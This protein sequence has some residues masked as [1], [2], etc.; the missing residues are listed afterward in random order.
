M[1]L[2]LDERVVVVTGGSSGIGLALVRLLLTE[3][4]RVATCGRSPERLEA[5]LA[6]LLADHGHRLLAQ[7]AD[8]TDGSA[9]DRL[10]TSTVER[11]GGID[12]LVNNA[13]QSRLST[14]ASTTDDEWRQELE[15][16]FFG[17]LHPIRAA[18]SALRAS[19]LGAIVNLGAVLARQPEERL[20]A[21]SAARAGALNL[22][23]SL[24]RELAPD[25]RVNS[26]LL[27]LID[28]GQW[29]RRFEAAD[30]GLDY[31]AWCAELAAD[32]GVP[33]ARLGRADEVAPTVALLVSPRSGY[34]TGTTIDVAGGVAR[35]V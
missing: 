28:T 4:A 30:T 15:L 24:A 29:R 27:G 12:G 14:F 10:M 3:G 26:V 2:G 25:I 11:W 20:V 5:A 13:G 35:Y 32:R 19:P 8:V 17:L 7:P 23:K 16:K 21:T 22:S 18:E 31:D 9:M 33:L 34:T 1:D 6:P